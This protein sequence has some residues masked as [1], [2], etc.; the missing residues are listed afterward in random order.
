MIS[1]EEIK[2]NGYAHLKVELSRDIDVIK[3]L[4]NMVNH[5]IADMEK[6]C[7]INQ[8]LLLLGKE[9]IKQGF[10]KICQSTLDSFSKTEAINESL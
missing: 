8:E 4:A 2:A 1:Y 6:D 5:L 9:N 7:S 3:T 10:I